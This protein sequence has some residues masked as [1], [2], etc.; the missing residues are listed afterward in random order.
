MATKLSR[1]PDTT[2]HFLGKLACLGNSG[3]TRTLSTILGV[4]EDEIHAA[5]WEWV[6]AGLVSRVNG[7]YGFLHD[8]VHEAAYALIS[9]DARVAVHLQIGRTLA[10]RTTPGEIDK[11]IFE[12]VNQL[13]RGAALIMRLKSCSTS[14]SSICAPASAPG[15]QQPMHRH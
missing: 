6:R 8:R 4:S 11:N 13:D 3:Q 2:R 1:L 10:A 5:L 14:R 15:L 7:A 9:E 12:I